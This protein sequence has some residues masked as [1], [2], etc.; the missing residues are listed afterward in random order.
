MSSARL[1]A[2]PG[3][4][5][6]GPQLA[7]IPL[8]VE[9]QIET[10]IIIDAKSG[11][12]GAGR[13]LKTSSL[14]TEVGEGVSAYNIAS[15]RHSPEIDQGLSEAANTQIKVSFTPHLIPMNRGILS[16][17]YLNL[18]EGTKFTHLRENLLQH[19]EGE[20][21]VHITSEGVVPNTKMVK[22]SNKCLIGVFND[23]VSNRIIILTAI[24][25]LIKGASGQALQ[26]MNLMFGIP[27][28]AGLL[29][30]PLSP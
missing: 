5:P 9:G 19:Y 26:N 23:R 29:Q 16:T 18:T 6:T 7:L 15:H 4:Y 8:L 30:L 21:F 1:V 28:T 22:G 27:E 24:D 11:V 13:E 3:C 2:N 10:N 25:N 12:S 14:Y 17:I 20:P